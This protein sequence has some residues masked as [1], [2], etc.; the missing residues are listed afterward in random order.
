MN[1]NYTTDREA[2][3]SD[4]AYMRQL[5]KDA[6]AMLFDRDVDYS[7]GSEFEHLSLELIGC[8]H[9][10]N[11]YIEQKRIASKR[12]ECDECG[13]SFNMKS[14]YDATQWSIAHKCDVA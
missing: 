6:R 7:L 13:V 8:A 12:V 9:T 2:V 4:F 1:T 5:L 11:E 3:I 14:P 10:L